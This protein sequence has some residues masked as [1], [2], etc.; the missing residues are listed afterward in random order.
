LKTHLTKA[1]EIQISYPN[2]PDWTTIEDSVLIELIYDYISEQSC[3]T[4]A[5][6]ILSLR[7]HKD[8]EIICIY[9]INEINADQWLKSTSLSL[10]LSNNFTKG[11]ETANHLIDNCDE[12]FLL[13][14]LEALN[15]EYHGMFKE[16][17]MNHEIIYKIKRRLS[18]MKDTKIEYRDM[19]YQ[20][21]GE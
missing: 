8:V 17:I 21:F 9:L 10:L 15:Y 2:E 7:K 4:S 14:I 16:F 3:A 6:N 11:V 18:S 13:S 20:N 5:I 19:F 12:S 1:Q